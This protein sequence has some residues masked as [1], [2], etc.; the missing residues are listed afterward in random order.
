LTKKRIQI[1]NEK[2]RSQLAFEEQQRLN[3]FHEEDKG[4]KFSRN[5]LRP[6][7]KHFDP[8][9]M[10]YYISPEHEDLEN[11]EIALFNYVPQGSG[12]HSWET[13]RGENLLDNDNQSQY[14]IRYGGR[15]YALPQDYEPSGTYMVL[16]RSYEAPIAK[17]YAE[18]A[19]PIIVPIEKQKKMSNRMVPIYQSKA[20]MVD[21]DYRPPDQKS[22]TFASEPLVSIPTIDSKM[23]VEA[24]Q[25]VDD[26]MLSWDFLRH[27]FK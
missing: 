11:A 2:L 16:S 4:N 22:R 15:L 13:E 14:N 1:L 5:K 8:T 20:K 10:N 26:M 9:R 23:G 3:L 7:F 19:P 6:E 24:N 25:P 12:Q 18:P 21:R 17:P 27:S